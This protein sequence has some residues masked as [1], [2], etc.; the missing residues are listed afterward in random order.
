LQWSSQDG[1]FTKDR[2]SKWEPQRRSGFFNPFP[3]PAETI[4][5]Q[6]WAT[7]MGALLG[8]ANA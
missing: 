1:D 3:S 7:D 8:E 6:Q 2:L 5:S 4:P